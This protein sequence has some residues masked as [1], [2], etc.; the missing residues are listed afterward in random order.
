TAV[1]EDANHRVQVTWRAELRDGARY[2][3]QEVTLRALG[4]PLPVREIA[5]VELRAR[6]AQLSGSVKGSPVTIGSWF[7]GLEH[8]LSQSTVDGDRVRCVLTRELPL[9][10]ESA[11][12]ISSV[13]GATRPGQMRRDFLAYVER[14]RAH[15]YRTFLHYNS[16]YDIGYFSQYSEPEALG[17]VQAFGEQ[18]VRQRGI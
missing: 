5:L 9:R 14:E 15:P 6:G 17:V 10:P 13:I 16:W 8:P 12:T 1:L 11:F 3:R 7:V 18:L 2:L 4:A